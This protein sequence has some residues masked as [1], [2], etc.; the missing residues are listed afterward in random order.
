MCSAIWYHGSMSGKRIEQSQLRTID[1]LAKELSSVTQL[2]FDGRTAHAFSRDAKVTII[3]IRAMYRSLT[4]N[5]SKN[6]YFTQSI[7][8]LLDNFPYVIDSALTELLERWQD[9]ETMHI[10]QMVDRNGKK[11]PRAYLIAHALTSATDANINRE[12]VLAFLDSYQRMAPLSIREL[13]IF[14]DMLRFVLLEETLRVMQATLDAYQEIAN[15][16]KWFIR[17]LD[18]VDRRESDE[19]LTQLTI[20]LAKQ[21]TVIPLHFSFH[22]LQ[23]I[24][25]SGKEKELRIMSKWLKLTLARRGFGYARLSNLIVRTDREQAAT[26]SA[27]ISALRWLAQMRWDRVSAPLNVVDAVLRRDPAECFEQLSDETL[28]QYRRAV[29][30]IAGKTGVHDVEVAREA[31]RFARLAQEDSGQPKRQSHVGYFLID[32]GVMALERAFGYRPTIRERLRRF[33]RAHA[34]QLYLGGIAFVT[35]LVVCIVFLLGGGARTPWFVDLLLFLATVVLASEVGSVCMHYLAVRLLEPRVLPCLNL[36]SGVGPDRR[37]LVVM[38][39]MLRNSESTQRLLRRLETNCIANVDP[40]VFFVA[41][42]DFRDSVEEFSETDT[43]LVAEFAVGIEELNARYPSTI[44]RFALFH[45]YRK[46]N[47]AE[48][49]YMGW[50]RK[51]GKLREFNELLRGKETSYVEGSLERAAQFGHVQYI[52]TIDE[53]TELVRDSASILIGTIDHPLNRPVIDPDRRVVTQGYGIIEPRLA[54]RFSEG[55]SSLFARL[56]GGFPGIEAYSSFISDLH[57]DLFGEGIFHGKGIYDIDAVEA[58][59]HDRIPENTILSHDLL[60]GLYARVGLASGAHILEGFPQGYHE[61]MKRAHRWTRGDW[62]IAQWA[63]TRRGCVFSAIGRWKIFDNLR[64]NMLPIALVAVVMATLFSHADVFIWSVVALGSLGFGQLFPALIH[65]IIT[66]TSLDRRTGLYYRLRITGAAIGVAFIKTILLGVFALHATVITLDAIT[67]SMWRLFI[68]KRKLLEWQ[69]AYE[70][71]A[72]ARKGIMHFIGFMWR[73]TA[74]S[75]VLMMLVLFAPHPVLEPVTLLW[76]IAWLSAPFV[77]RLMSYRFIRSTRLR[78]SDAQYLRTIAAR[79]YWFFS[80]M[81]TKESQWLVPDHFQEEPVAKRHMFGLGLSPTNLGMYLLSLSAGRA[82]GFVDMKRYA[83]RIENAFRSID[84]LERYRGH[85]FNWYELKGLSALRPKYVSSVDSANLALSLVALRGAIGEALRAP[86]VSIEMITGADASLAVLFDACQQAL[87]VNGLDIED[88]NMILA[89][90][91]TTVEARA[92]LARTGAFPLTVQLCEKTLATVSRE[93]SSV[94]SMVDTLHTRGRGD[95]YGDVFFAA[96]HSMESIIAM[97]DAVELYCGYMVAP[98][99]SCVDSI[100]S[101]RV[102]YAQLLEAIAHIPT[103]QT[104]SDGTI[105]EQLDRIGFAKILTTVDASTKDIA[106][107][108]AWHN[109]FLARL[110]RSE[111]AARTVQRQLS[112]A[113]RLA[114]GYVDTMDFTFLYDAERG[115]FHSG[116]NATTEHLDDAFYDLLASEANSAS[117]FGIAKRAVPARHWTYLGRKLI[118]GRGGKALVASWA[119]SLFEYLGTLIYFD[120]PRKSFWGISARRA[121]DSHRRFAHRLGIPWGMGESASADLDIEHNY[122][123]QAFGDPSLG[124][125]RGLSEFAVVAPYATAL[126]LPFNPSLAI[127]NFRALMRAGAFGGYGF[128]DAID[129]T[130]IE[131]NKRMHGRPARIY[132]AHHQGF[133]LTSIA[134]ALMNGWV[135]RLVAEDPAMVVATQL[136]EE[137]MPDVPTVEPVSAVA[138]AVERVSLRSVEQ[139]APRRY[140]PVRTKEAQLRVLSN[141]S[142][143]VSITSTGAGSSRYDNLRIT[144]KCD[145]M[146][147]ESQGTFFYLFDKKRNALWSPTFMPTKTPGARSNVSVGEEVISFEKIYEGIT[148]RMTVAVDPHS[149]VEVRELSL[150]N[151]RTEPVTLTIG[152]CADIALSRG[153]AEAAHPNYERLFIASTTAFDGAASLFSRPDPRDREKT[154]SAGAMI[155]S[156]DSISELAAVRGREVFFGS[157]MYKREPAIMRDPS[158]AATELP[159]YTL[160]SAAGFVW[161]M[162][163]KPGET[164]NVAFVLAAGDSNTSVERTLEPF[165]SY[166]AIERLIHNADKAGGYLL[167][168]LA[169]SSSQAETFSALASLLSVRSRYTSTVEAP[170]IPAIGSVWKCGISGTRPIFVLAVSAV[171]HLSIIRQVISCHTY[172]IKKGIKAD[173]VIFNEHAGGY[174]KTFEDEIDFL[175]YTSTHGAVSETSNIVHVRGDQFSPD[176]QILLRSVTPVWIDARKQTL[177]DAVSALMRMP[178]PLVPSKLIT[179]EQTQ[180]RIKNIVLVED[181]PSSLMF[182]NGFGGFDV[183]THDYVIRMTKDRRPPVPWTNVVANPHF[184]FLATDR[185]MSFTWGLNSVENKLT[186][187]YNDPLASLTGE[188]IYVRDNRT[189]EFWSPLQVI[190]DRTASYEVRHGQGYSLY[191]TLQGGLVLALRMTIDP[192]HPIKYLSLSVRNTASTDRD[193]SVLGYFEL[194]LGNTIKETG[195]HLS[196]SLLSGNCIVARQSRSNAFPDLRTVVGIA[197]G[198]DHFTLSKKEFVGRFNDLRTPD[199]IAS[200]QL[201]SD[202]LFSGE[203]CAALSHSILVQAGEEVTVDFFMGETDQNSVTALYERANTAGAA[204]AAFDASRNHWDQLPRVSF[205]LPDASLALL[206]NR[207]LPYQ[208]LTSRIYGRTG[209]AQ[210]GG[211]FG[212][213]DQLQDALALLWI[214][215]QWVRSHIL[216]S[217]AHQ[218]IEGDVLSWW[219]PHNNFGARTRLSDPHLWL[220]YVVARYIRFTGDTSILDEKIPYLVG[221]IPDAGTQSVVGIFSA[222]PNS[223]SLYDHCVRAIEHALTVGPNGLP[224]MGAADWNDGLNNVGLEGRGESV[225]LAWF[226][227]AV[228]RDMRAMTDALGDHDRAERYTKQE[229]AYHDAIMRHGWDG[230][231]FRRAYTDTGIPIGA[232]TAKEFRIDSVVQ[233]WAQ[234]IDGNTPEVLQALQSAKEELHIWDGIVSLAWPPSTRDELDLGTISDYAP[235]IRENGAQYNHAALWFARAL[236]EAG[237]PDSAMVIIDAVNP[238]KRSETPERAALYRGEPYAV[239]ADIY[240][241]PTYEGRAGWTWYTASSGLFYRTV[242]EQLL[243]LRRTGEWLS[244]VPVFPSDWSEASVIIPFGATSYHIR[245][246]VVDVGSVEAPGVVLDGVR[247]VENKILL[248]DDKRE[249]VVIVRFVRRAPQAK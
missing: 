71:A 19:R 123:Y 12:S 94:G 61:Y 75:F 144:E 93:L 56:F 37:T 16:E 213:R 83:E 166:S 172:F 111:E 164:Q 66:A 57:Q 241:K 110:A 108:Y 73:S 121:I 39:S 113:K 40:D 1:R 44:P 137:K 34:T 54:V 133:I 15:A 165:R 216:A 50:E 141:G 182:E 101:L 150:L 170:E 231:W 26:F 236:F 153:S 81:A 60:E 177:A 42:M 159:Q 228:L 169:I 49:V 95:V 155:V 119:G 87:R 147:E 154:V 199:A 186:V 86:L 62:Q 163:I 149:P 85:F 70:T 198:A 115:L 82:M 215:S 8:L 142:Y 167:D 235:G 237:D 210:I 84:R 229:R 230:K 138:P 52:V 48:K 145:N 97:H 143:H 131:K 104:L 58:T 201:S 234:F 171:T 99:I 173:I 88:K 132:F 107:V 203:P 11:R 78:A 68:S 29:V 90:R 89:I 176:E 191:N 218:F 219:H 211:A 59:M 126:A 116:F 195:K 157:P 31:V 205:D 161:T 168:S 232:A 35:A 248:V 188:A 128:Y 140:I 247:A 152:V 233:S 226:T 187:P 181:A 55:T 220:P 221:D 196:F 209:F 208:T 92:T 22:L 65:A 223:E 102:P 91:T 25:Q 27:A 106:L 103:I 47:V 41:L 246:E 109:E 175:L 244:F 24:S 98:V 67:R 240:A 21:Y 79:T 7:E 118:K 13:D 184:G 74:I 136:F 114:D 193:L 162:T 190:G 194:L 120:V 158:R 197:G 4:D 124:Y 180:K 125:K 77:A 185:G 212:F 43:A 18:A 189:G 3:R 17:V 100:P 214:D 200:A 130:G 179:S 183:D 222:G 33:V 23:R 242:I 243:G 53:D 224:L 225:W 238:I 69:T 178:E 80:D 36:E 192:D 51:R 14:P 249:H 207:L 5:F 32:E 76:A 135:R 9:R 139:D 148:S 96:R 6:I 127:N 202:V 64:R 245:Y 227:I 206:C 160:D 134:N 122:H 30:R 20:M 151:R 28:G 2:S 217:A 174:L 239:A 38:P 204:S 63:F 117:I 129:Y 10:P 46:W 112:V 105:R 45:R 156:S 72:R 146:L